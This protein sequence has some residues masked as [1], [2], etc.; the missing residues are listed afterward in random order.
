[1]GALL[2]VVGPLGVLNRA[3]LTF[4]RALG[5]VAVGLM[6]VAILVQVLL[7]LHPQ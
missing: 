6:V 3:M 2:A 1:M 4:G 5:S 7:S